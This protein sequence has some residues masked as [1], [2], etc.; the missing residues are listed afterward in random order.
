MSI[1]WDEIPHLYGSLLLA[2]GRSNEYIATYGYYP[3]LYDIVTLAYFK[4][5]GIS[6]AVGRLAAVTFSLL[7]VWITFEFAKRIYGSKTA[8]LASIMLGL[9]P[10]FFWISRVAMLETMLMFFFSLSLF[11]FFYWNRFNNNRSLIL[12][13]LALGVGF[14]AKYQIAV[15]GLVMIGII[16]FFSRDKL[17]TRLSKFPL[18]PIIAIC[19]SIP[20]F[21]ILFQ[22]Y[23][24]EKMGELFYVIQEGGQDRAIYSSR[25]QPFF[26][27]YL[28]EITWPYNEVH[29]I[30][31]PLY[32]FGLLGLA[33]WTFRRK[34][35]DKFFLAWFIIVYGFFTLI[36]NKQW[37]Y[38]TPLF[39]VL[40]IS[41]A[42]FIIF[43][44]NK[45][46]LAFASES[47]SKRK[48]DR[49]KIADSRF[50]RF[51]DIKLEKSWNRWFDLKKQL[52]CK[53]VTGFFI[54]IVATAVVHGSIETYNMVA[55][56]QI[57]I[58]IEEATK[59][60]IE[61]MDQDQGIMIVCAFNLFNKDMVKFYLQ[62][63]EYKQTQVLQYPILPVDSFK[64]NFETEEVIELCQTENV[65]YIFLYE[66]GG[67]VEYFNST[68]TAMG[69][70]EKLVVNG[71]GRF[72]FE[73]EVGS[74]PR[75]ITIFSFK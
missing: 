3:P 58:P 35:E 20:W 19:V 23:G 9:M 24:L 75:T 27:F 37:R 49:I 18:L 39:P 60:A 61:N 8:L 59:F 38:V 5:F 33:L 71:T 11:F 57:H 6:E 68:L 7:T 64:P 50:I 62:T 4:I 32:I 12:C 46:Q 16:L 40:A 17:R 44:F 73:H 69:V 22:M 14:L 31:L 15:A 10:G 34:S 53:I 30:A 29:P 2:Q 52:F 1:Q 74:H 65:K 13:G 36:P 41:A 63:Y 67:E 47:F 66:Y 56:D 26:I 70:Y 21:L 48:R 51:I 28:I 45:L 55:R 42:S 43:A 72:E 25:F 54:A